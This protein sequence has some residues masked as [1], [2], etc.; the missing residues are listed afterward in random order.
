MEVQGLIHLINDREVF[1]S[2]FSKR[3]LVIKTTDQYPQYISIDFLKDKGDLL[4]NYVVGQEVKVFINL[5]GRIWTDPQGVD[6]FFNSVTGWKIESIA[7]VP[8]QEQSP[9]DQFEPTSGI[10]DEDDDEMPF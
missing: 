3:N 10:G 6:K 2:G 5:G 7:Q 9:L 1:S 4:N 8:V